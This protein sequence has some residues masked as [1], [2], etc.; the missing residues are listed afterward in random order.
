VLVGGKGADTLEGAG[1]DDLIDPITTGATEVVP[2]PEGQQETT[3][4]TEVAQ[5]KVDAAKGKK[6]LADA[7]VVQ[8]LETV[9]VKEQPKIAEPKAARQ[10]A[11]NSV[12]NEFAGVINSRV[13][14]PY[15]RAA[16]FNTGNRESRYSASN[17]YRNWND[18]GKDGNARAGGIMSWRDNPK[19]KKPGRG[20]EHHRRGLGIQGLQQSEKR[21]KTGS[22]GR[23]QKLGDR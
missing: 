1:E 15:A 17:A 2:A 20:A 6:T 10:H 3:P 22:Y 21:G 9:A 5:A 4:E 19:V 23:G 16:I 11:K 7:P 18:P 12:Y 14:N 13:K 8:P